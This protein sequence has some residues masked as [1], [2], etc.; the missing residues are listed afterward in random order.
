[1]CLQ[2]IRGNRRNNRG[3]WW[4]TLKILF[5][6]DSLFPNVQT[7]LRKSLTRIELGSDIAA[8]AAHR[9]KEEEK[10]NNKKNM[11]KKKKG[12][13]RIRDSWCAHNTRARMRE[14]DSRSFGSWILVS[15]R[16]GEI[17]ARACFAWPLPDTHA[18][19]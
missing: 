1:M 11:K 17:L 15:S 3:R 19:T 16:R 14:G 8:S 9:T 6:P 4:K 18:H 12:Q 10:K 5:I 7:P 13:R 2:K